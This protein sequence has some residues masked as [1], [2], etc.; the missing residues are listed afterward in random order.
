[1]DTYIR[2]RIDTTMKTQAEQACKQLGISL[3]DYIRLSLS[4]LIE[5]EPN[6][7]TKHAI[8]DVEARKGLKTGQAS[9][10]MAMFN[11]AKKHEKN[12]ME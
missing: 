7:E 1:M 11:K 2:A 12:D 4:K 5:H 10:I 8:A 3:S 6:Q 9:D